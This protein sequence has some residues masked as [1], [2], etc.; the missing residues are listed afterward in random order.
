[1]VVVGPCESMVQ[2]TDME[3]AQWTLMYGSS[4]GGGSVMCRNSSG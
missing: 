3:V 4:G 1:M 2:D